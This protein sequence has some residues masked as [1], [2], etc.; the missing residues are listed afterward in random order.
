MVA[1]R[2]TTSNMP[3]T[4]IVAPVPVPVLWSTAAGVRPELGRRR[5]RTAEVSLVILGPSRDLGTRQHG[6]VTWCAGRSALGRYERSAR[7]RIARH[8]RVAAWAKGVG[9]RT[10][11]DAENPRIRQPYPVV[12]AR[13]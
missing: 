8:G 9:R 4:A 10:A 3:S 13:G 12:P 2:P 7:A 5:W 1:W 6:T 11:V